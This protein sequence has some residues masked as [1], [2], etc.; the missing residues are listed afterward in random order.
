M[1]S[2]VMPVAKSIYFCDDILPDAAR[3]KLLI[4]GMFNAVRVPEGAAFPYKLEKMSIFAQLIGGIG[5][6]PIR[7][8]IVRAATGQI[9]YST[10]PRLLPFRNRQTTVTFTLRLSPFVIPAPGAIW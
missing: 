7:L 9:L 10:G 2:V 1:A 8:D 6:V 5:D 3:N 4:V